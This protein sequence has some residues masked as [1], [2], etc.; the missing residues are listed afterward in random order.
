M[1]KIKLIGF[2]YVNLVKKIFFKFD[3][4]SV[5][6]RMLFFGEVLGRFFLFRILTKLVFHFK[7]HSLEQV[8]SGITFKNPVGLSAGF[9]KNVKLLKILPSV[10]FAHAEFGSVTYGAY[11]G[12]PKPRLYRLPKS[13]ALTVYYGLK[14]EGVKPILRRIQKNYSSKSDFVIGI[15]VART[16]S[17]DTAELN[18]GILDYTNCIREVVNSG[19]AKYITINISCPNT[20]GGEPFTTP[21]R[22]EKLLSSIANV[23]TRIPLFVKMPIDLPWEEFDKLLEIIVKHKFEGVVIGNLT[24]NRKSKLIKDFIPEEIKG[25]ISGL[26]T[27]HLSD[28]L[29]RRTYL[30]YGKKLVIVGVGGIFSAEDAY[31]KIK[32][33]ASLVQLIT[34]MIYEG[35]QLIGSINRGLKDLLITDGF[36]NISEA[37]GVDSRKKS[38]VIIKK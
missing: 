27:Q 32:L 6:D 9:D 3:P 20:F 33:G 15:S 12:N 24:K 22:L 19:L 1:V 35:P 26:P 10:G 30:K 23:K 11:E 31:R 28:E 38:T 13:K 21:L 2:L 16:N 17:D 34:G 18:A 7:D 8:I 37:I 29:I 14:N 4:E 36:S 5:H 25:G